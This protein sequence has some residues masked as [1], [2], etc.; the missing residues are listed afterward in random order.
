LDSLTPKDEEKGLTKEEIS[1]AA[2]DK[3][4]NSLYLN[5]KLRNAVRFTKDIISKEVFS[6]TDAYESLF[7]NILGI[8]NGYDTR[9]EMDGTLNVGYK[10]VYNKKSID[11]FA[12]GIDN[13][14][15][16]NSFMNLG[17]QIYKNEVSRNDE[18]HMIDFT[19]GGDIN[20]VVDKF[21]ELTLGSKK[22]KSIFVRLAKLINNIKKDPY[23]EKADGLV[24]GDGEI[25]NDLLLYL[26]PQTPNDKYP[27]GRMLL[28]NS[29]TE[30][31]SSEERRLIS[32]FAQ[33]LEHPN[34]EVRQLASD[35]AFYAYF[36]TYDQ[37]TSNS[38][39]HLVPVE[40]RKQYDLALRNSLQALSSRKAEIKTKAVRNAGGVNLA[41]EL[42]E[43]DVEV[44]SASN[45]IDVLSR[46][47]WYD[48]NIVPVHYTTTNQPE[49]RFQS[50][51]LNGDT[52]EFT[53]TQIYDA[54]SGRMFPT[55]IASTRVR[56]DS[57]YIKI[58]KG[59]GTFLYKRVG[60]VNRYYTD[61]K[62]N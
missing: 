58:R 62:G 52:E 50:S 5:L 24:N 61:K 9:K 2:L 21:K 33:L 54:E 35:L 41:L 27:I 45:M 38:F 36:S 6:A 25:I 59:S 11:S 12:Q 46:N 47:Y 49:S 34:E 39:F 3:Y 32:A 23:S 26:N 15:R 48:D 56:N 1:T 42:S 4:F 18:T 40:H 17:Y 10:P 43:R 7:K 31:K 57:M 20:A 13:M 53:G 55:Y 22:Q 44:V 14:M 60:T 16:F 28:Q 37:N 30:N 29:Q 19:M 51:G 8:I